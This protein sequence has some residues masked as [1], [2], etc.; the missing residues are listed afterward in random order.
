MLEVKS[1][2]MKSGMLTRR[3]PGKLHTMRIYSEKLK[4]AQATII[5]APSCEELCGAR[6]ENGI[7][8]SVM[9]V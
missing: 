3:T 2:G 9:G 5:E 6:V 1:R 7:S 8:I 4:E